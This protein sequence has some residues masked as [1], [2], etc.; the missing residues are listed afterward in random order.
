M[1]EPVEAQ[2]DRRSLGGRVVEES[3]AGVGFELPAPARV[4]LVETARPGRTPY[5]VVLAQ[6]AWNVIALRELRTRLG[7]Y[8]PAQW[9]R[10]L[11]RRGVPG[12]TSGAPGRWSA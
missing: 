1:P 3:L 9:P 6:N 10:F 5:D 11:A 2:P 8:P 7:E 4:A 12:S